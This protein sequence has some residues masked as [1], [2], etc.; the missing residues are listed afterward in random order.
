MNISFNDYIDERTKIFLVTGQSYS[1]HLERLNEDTGMYEYVHYIS[2]AGA[3]GPTKTVA[4]NPAAVSH[5][6]IL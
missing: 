4:I 1:G 6:E 3:D 2:M 5:I